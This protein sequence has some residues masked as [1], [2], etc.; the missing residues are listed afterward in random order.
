M[1][2]D[3]KHAR[4]FRLPEPTV[5]ADILFRALHTHLEQLRTESAIIAVHLRVKPAR[6]PVRQRGLFETELNDPHGFA[7]TLARVVAVVGSGR[8]GTPYVQDTHR[9]DAAVMEAPTAVVP[10]AGTPPVL[11]PLGLPLRRFRPPRPVRVEME[12]GA[13]VSLWGDCARGVIAVVRGP[14][15]GR[16]DWWETERVW[17]RE[18]WDVEVSGGGLYRLIRTPDGWFVEGEYD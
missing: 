17:K 15:R 7:E 9:P 8:V 12:N 5:K 1:S 2:D 11:P 13:P 10:P 6:P 14:W 4:S 16:G 18:E 3:T